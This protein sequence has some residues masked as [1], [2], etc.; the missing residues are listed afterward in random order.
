M[1]AQRPPP[2]R[3]SGERPEPG[4]SGGRL[5]R[6]GSAGERDAGRGGRGASGALRAR[7]RNRSGR[8]G[9]SP[10][11][12]G[13][14]GPGGRGAGL[15][16]CPLRPRAPLRA[17]HLRRRRPAPLSAAPARSLSSRPGPAGRLPPLLSAGRSRG[18][19]SEAWGRRAVRRSARCAAGCPARPCRP[20]AA[21]RELCPRVRSAR[22]CQLAARLLRLTE[23]VLAALGEEERFS[24]G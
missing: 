3:V 1:G 17:S 22:V 9:S 13:G 24:G 23:L 14:R 2:A 20:R 15:A 12:R 21:G 16:R 8:R 18:G 19:R 4:R 11:A 7:P 10:A 6:A 5:G